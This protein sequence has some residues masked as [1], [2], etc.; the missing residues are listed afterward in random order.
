MVRGPR[1]RAKLNTYYDLYMETGKLDPN[2]NP[3][4]GASWEK[5]RNFGAPTDRIHTDHRLP[6]ADFAARQRLHSQAMEYLGQLTAGLRDFFKEYDISLLL[7]DDE[8]VVLKSYTMPFY[9]LTPGEIEG[10]RVG[11]EEIGTSSVS[12]A[13]EEKGNCL[14]A[15]DIIKKIPQVAKEL[16]E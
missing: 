12:L 1:N 5:S 10:V 11:V 15:G 8:C 4:I 6:A 2:V 14:L 16:S 7:L 9:Q 13:Y 3:E